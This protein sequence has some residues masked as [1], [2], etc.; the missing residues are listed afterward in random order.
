MTFGTTFWRITEK[1]GDKFDFDVIAFTRRDSCTAAALLCK[2]LK[3]LFLAITIT[4]RRAGQQTH[5]YIYSQIDRRYKS[6]GPSGP[7]RG[8]LYVQK[9][10]TRE[11]SVRG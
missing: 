10:C 5:I 4:Q 2:S 3:S 6:T 1:K 8:A 7:L 11:R 9:D